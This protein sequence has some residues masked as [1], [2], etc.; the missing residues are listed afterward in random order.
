M[1]SYPSI[2]HRA[3]VTYVNPSTG[4]I[5]VK[6]PA[7]TG[8]NTEISISRIGRQ[9]VNGVWSMPPVGEQIVVSADDAN[10][11]NVFW[12]QTDIGSPPGVTYETKPTITYTT[13]IGSPQV[14]DYSKESFGVSKYA[15]F[16]TSGTF[17]CT[18]AGFCNVIVTGGGGGGGS[19]GGGGGGGE[20]T[21]YIQVFI[22]TGT[23]VITIGAGG[24]GGT[25]G[26]RGS[27]G[28]ATI[29]DY[30]P[31]NGGP[32]GY[33]YFARGGGGGGGQNAGGTGIFGQSAH[34]GAGG[35]S[36][37]AAGNSLAYIYG[38]SITSGNGGYSYTGSPYEG[39]GGGGSR[40]HGMSATPFSGGDGG[41][42]LGIN[43][44]YGFGREIVLGAG[45][46]GGYH[47]NYP[48]YPGRGGSNEAG[49]GFGSG[50]GQSGA[51][52]S[53]G[54]GGGGGYDSNYS[55]YYNGGGGGNGSVFLLGVY[56]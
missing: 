25:N 38:R 21:E 42:G 50:S 1:H 46:G 48:G 18:S 36:Y 37:T 33:Q 6:I 52:G 34:G 5:R 14:G 16:F 53:G 30:L 51:S 56:V 4:E 29:I 9:P 31:T 43:F 3:L 45:G 13:S 54:G 27:T 49:S 24:A 44:R 39:G 41:S 2:V 11:T 8:N 10:M 23:Y 47:A 12:L 26:G 40:G 15:R 20:V 55:G 32:E 28:G 35:H 7:V 22:D 17:T 19:L